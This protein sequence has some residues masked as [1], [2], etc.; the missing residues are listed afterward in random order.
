[1]HAHLKRVTERKSCRPAF[2]FFWWGQHRC[3]GAHK[4]RDLGVTLA[5][6]NT[7]AWGLGAE[8]GEGIQS[9]QVPIA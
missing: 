8:D 7:Q 1:M 3:L 4:P 6:G 2:T 5:Y 9:I